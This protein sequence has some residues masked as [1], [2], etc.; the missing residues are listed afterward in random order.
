MSYYLSS[1]CATVVLYK[2]TYLLTANEVSVL[3]GCVYLQRLLSLQHYSKTV[4]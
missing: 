3:I 4:S 2:F 1:T